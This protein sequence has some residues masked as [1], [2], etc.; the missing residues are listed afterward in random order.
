[1]LCYSYMFV[2]SF[3][4]L[5]NNFVIVVVVVVT[6][7]TIKYLFLGKGGGRAITSSLF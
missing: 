4:I 5:V 7:L 1:M 2:A 6:T 3:P